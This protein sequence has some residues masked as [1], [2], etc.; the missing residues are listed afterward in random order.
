M[1]L[2]RQS[3]GLGAKGHPFPSLNCENLTQ[4]GELGRVVCS[5]QA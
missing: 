5:V 2:K 3:S 1:D 4:F